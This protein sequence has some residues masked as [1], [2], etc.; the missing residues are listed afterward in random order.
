[1]I[2]KRYELRTEIGRGAMGVVWRAFDRETRTDVAIKVLSELAAKHPLL[3]ERFE[4]E[5]DSVATVRH[6]NV[7]ACL[8]YGRTDDRI[9]YIVM[10]LLEGRDLSVRLDASPPINTTELRHIAISALA[11]LEAVHAV[12]LVHRDVKPTNIFLSDPPEDP[13]VRIVDFGL[14]RSVVSGTKSERRKITHTGELVGTPLYMSPEQIRTPSRVDAR[15]DLYS[16][17]V[18]LYEALA[19]SLPFES[20]DI[21][22]VLSGIMTRE[23]DRLDEVRPS[24]VRPVAMAIGKAL[25]KQPSGRYT[26]AGAMRDALV[27]AWSTQPSVPLPRAATAALAPTMAGGPPSRGG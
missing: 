2:S 25:A 20:R 7:V 27:E 18:C 9:P 6:A 13:R 11:G 4:R 12:G 10:E 8:D 16:L 19:G 23:P 15:T 17:G 1:M 5:A 24:I 26:T 14:S 3:G 21:G 22:A